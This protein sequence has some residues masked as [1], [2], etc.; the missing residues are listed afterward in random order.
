MIVNSRAIFKFNRAVDVIISPTSNNMEIKESEAVLKDLRTL[1]E[2][3]LLISQYLTNQNNTSLSGDKKLQFVLLELRKVTP[4][5]NDFV[6]W[7]IV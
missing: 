2:Y 5:Y 1:H 4:I 3:R 6:W 7:N